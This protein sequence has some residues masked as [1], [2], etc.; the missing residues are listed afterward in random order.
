L[1]IGNHLKAADGGS[2]RNVVKLAKVAWPSWRDAL[3]SLS[4]TLKP[5]AEAD[6]MNALVIWTSSVGEQIAR[7]QDAAALLGPAE[8]M[9]ERPVVVTPPLTTMP[10]GS[11]AVYEIE[12]GGKAWPARRIQIEFRARESDAERV[13]HLRRKDVRLLRLATCMRSAV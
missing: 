8:V 13:Q 11:F 4:W 12:A 2:C 9:P 1:A 7:F 5:H 10:P 6:L 3:S